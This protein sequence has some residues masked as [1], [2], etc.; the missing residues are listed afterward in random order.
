MTVNLELAKA[1]RAVSDARIALDWSRAGLAM[2]DKRI[3]SGEANLEA[4][5]LAQGQEAA[6]NQTRYQAAR[7]AYHEL[8]SGEPELW[9]HD[10]RSDPLLL[11]PL[12][13][14]TVYRNAGEAALEL[15][16]RAYPDDIHI[17]S[18]EPALTPAER[19]AAEAYWAEVWAAGPNEE[20]RK[21]A[22]AQLVTALG[23]GRAAWAVK[24]LRP[25]RQL[26]PDTETP[27]GAPAPSPAPWAVEPQTRD[28]RWTRPAHTYV[29]PDRLV[30]SAFET[31]GDGQLGLVWREE[32]AQIPEVL[33]VGL[34]PDTPV[35]PAWLGDFEEAVR[36]GMGVKV[37][38]EGEMRPDFSLV[39]VAGVRGGT[40]EHTAEL[41]G[42]LLDAHRCTDGLGVLPTGTPTNNT[43]S[44]RSAW[45]TRMPPPSPETADAQRAVLDGLAPGSPQAA[46]R[47]A[48]A[49][50][51]AAGRVLA[52]TADGLDADDHELLLQLHAG[53][54]AMAAASTNWKNYDSGSGSDTETGSDTGS[55]TGSETDTVSGSGSGSGSDFDTQVDLTFLVKHFVDHVR[56]RGHLPTLRVGRQ[57]YGILPATSLDLWRGTEVDLRILEQIQGFRTFAESQAWRSPTV[58]TGD[59]D[60]VFNKLLHRLP[61]SRRVRFVQQEPVSAP[62]QPA[63]DTPV[64]NIPYKSGFAWQMPPDLAALPLPL[65]FTLTT[66]P[67]PEVGELVRA[68][69][70]RALFSTLQELARAISQGQ[71]AP[72]AAERL[73]ALRPAFDG[74]RDGRL[75]LWYHLAITSLNLYFFRLSPRMQPGA[76]VDTV[77]GLTDGQVTVPPGTVP[78][79]F[80]WAA[81]AIE[82][83]AVAEEMADGDLP[84]LEQLLYEVLDTQSH[85]LDAWMT[86]VASA[87][88][89]RLRHDR[90]DGTHLGAYGW[91]TDLQPRGWTP[92]SVPTDPEDDQ[93][94]PSEDS[95][96]PVDDQALPSE[97]SAEP[98]DGTE[99]PPADEGPQENHDGYL[100]AP[101]LHQATTAAVLRSGWLA[102]ADAEAFRVDLKAS[103]VRRALEVVDGIRSGQSLGALLGYRLER[104]FHDA[105]LDGLIAPF[106]AAYPTA[107]VAEPDAPDSEQ[108][109]KATAERDVVDGRAL[110]EDFIAHGRTLQDL[111]SLTEQLTGDLLPLRDQA[112]PLVAD[113]EATVDAVGDLL[114][115]ESVHHMVAGNPLRAGAAADGIARGENLPQDFDVLRTPRAAVALTHRLGLLA[116]ASGTNG[117]TAG[118]PLAALEPAL[119]RWC[120]NRLGDASSWSF[121]FGDP[122]APT[123]VTLADLGVC[124]LDVALG[125][126]MFE[127]GTSRQPGSLAGP[128]SVL[129]HRLLDHVGAAGQVTE[130]GAARFAELQLLC[131]SLAQVFA[132]ARPLLVTDLDTAAGDDWSSADLPELA[133]RISV[134]HGATG[135][136]IAELRESVKVLPGG[137]DHV[138][139]VMRTL[140][141]LGVPGAW[142]SPAPAAVDPT[143]AL[144]GQAVAVV[145][146]FDTEPLAPLPG[147]PP[148]SPSA[149]LEW[150]TRLRATV[151]SVLGRTLPVV[152][153]LRLDG[154]AAATA[155]T[156]PAAQG[157]TEDTVAEWLLHMERVR[158][159]TRAFG[160]ALMAAE[161]LAGTA[162][163]STVVAQLP[164][165]QPWIAQGPAPV[166]SRRHPAP[167]HCAVLRV[168]GPPAPGNTAGLIVDAWTETVPEPATGDRAPEELGGL[169]FHYNQPDARAPQALLLALPP[170]HTRGWCMEDVHAVIEETFALARLR[171]MDL[172]DLTELRGLL[173]VQ[174]TKPAQGWGGPL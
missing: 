111:D 47:A 130:A 127:D 114:L 99:V 73:Q 74:T 36:V 10:S 5:H 52:E 169:A 11:L 137:A 49:L 108:A 63:P 6:T 158:P 66:E 123:Q 129:A 97:D 65:E 105:Q 174:W 102:H 161:T 145:N 134:W 86:S 18:H 55:E 70:V 143:E 24:A 53:F 3:E 126:G 138:I 1:H 69:P 95:A 58:G 82:Q 107:H 54:G 46:A 50:G 37:L 125:A 60:E 85:R 135:F 81:L 31:V 91:V 172:S 124:A 115:A 118:R 20:R 162:P 39:T 168:D 93:A 122:A 2:Y 35:P 8:A 41:I 19:T 21:A 48:R 153:V 23:P 116:P 160:D 27:A 150:V 4:E 106:R 75:G 155:L 119:E 144:R 30:F 113:L 100:V 34:G 141:D 33:D 173:P 22:W 94:L 32:G 28:G 79:F 110:V 170:D 109:R 17:D 157:A 147:P 87:R 146:R 83:F 103:R 7:D 12:R 43:E 166:P 159:Q 132:A 80:D 112:E 9:S 59:A 140:A 15:W 67:A 148:Q 131:R 142:P 136:A 152:P 139:R 45:R 92:E 165:G 25:S 89:N 13:L 44:T 133:A 71:P 77:V 98:V 62:F 167:H 64:G 96:E 149:V 88:M 78:T 16:I 42:T 117:W 128:D 156:G 101:S 121:A 163:C 68:H 90:P 38:I 51:P 57:P 40:S 56:A 84:R 61:A 171:G 154:S 29:L 26:P 120:Q 104:A 164:V 72:D 76:A 14:E 151:S